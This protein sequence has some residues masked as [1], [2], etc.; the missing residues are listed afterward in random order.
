MFKM[1]LVFMIRRYILMHAWG[2]FLD[3]IGRVVG[4]PGG[5]MPLI[6]GGHRCVECVCRCVCGCLCVGDCGGHVGRLYSALGSF[7]GGEII[8]PR[9]VLG[10]FGYVGHPGGI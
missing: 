2:I 8:Y 1:V 10:C 7:L 5:G 6:A 9:G 4:H 3:Q